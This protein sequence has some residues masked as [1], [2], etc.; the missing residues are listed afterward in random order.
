MDGVFGIK[1][2]F[3]PIYP[4]L[5]ITEAQDEYERVIPEFPV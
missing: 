1:G 5:A 4:K 2:A 3:S